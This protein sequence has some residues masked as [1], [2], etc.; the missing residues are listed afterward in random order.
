MLRPLGR[1]DF[2]L[3]A[4]WLDD[5]E[6]ARWWPDPHDPADLEAA[7][8]PTID[9]HD[10]TEVLVVEEDGAPVGLV[11]RYRLAD[12]PAWAASLVPA[13]PFGI[14]Y[15]LGAPGSRGR[16]LGT[17]IVGRF[18]ADSWDRYPGCHACVVGVDRD[19]AAS[20]GLLRRLGFR[21]VYEG[22]LL[23]PAPGDGGVQVVL[24]LDR[25]DLA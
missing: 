8:G 13:D 22:G 3:L 16:G 19:N 7:C 2:D 12:E 14:D 9:D 6:V 20:L 21:T 23:D 1:A 17:R 25:T 5:P 10:P 24:V 18:V 4:V 11:Q 15:L